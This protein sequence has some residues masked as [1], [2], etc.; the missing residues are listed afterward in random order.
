[1]YRAIFDHAP[2]AMIFLDDRGTILIANAA[3]V[4]LFEIPL[5]DLLGSHLRSYESRLLS[6]DSRLALDCFRRQGSLEGSFRLLTGNQTLRDFEFHVTGS[7]EGEHHL[8]VCR[9]VTERMEVERSLRLREKQLAQAQAIAQLG[10]WQWSPGHPAIEVS[11][12]ALRI[13]GF[14]AGEVDATTRLFRQALHPEDRQQVRLALWGA[15][16]RRSSFSVDYR[17]IRQDGATRTIRQ[18]GEASIGEDGRVRLLGVIRDI[19]EQKQIQEAR[20]KALRD[21]AAERTW[22]STL[23]ERS[24]VAF[25]LLGDGGRRVVFNRR[26]QE[27][28]GGDGGRLSLQQLLT[29]VCLPSGIRM[30]PSELPSTRALVGEWVLSEE[31]ALRRRDGTL[32]PA[33]AS[34][35]PI[36]D[37]DGKRLGAVVVFEDIRALKALDRMREEWT[38]IVAHDLRQP[39]TVIST[40]GQLLARKLGQTNPEL[41]APSEHILAS[42]GLLNRMVGDLLDMS[43]IEAHRLSLELQP[44]ELEALA[45]KV[46]ERLSQELEQQEVVIDASSPLPQVMVDPIRF[47]QILVN[48]LSNAAK[49]GERSAA[50]RVVLRR[51]EEGLTIEVIN[52]GRGI[53]QE[54]LAN[55]FTRFHRTDGAKKSRV[56]GLGLGLYITRGLVE[57]HGGGISAESSPGGNT[58]FRISLPH[59]SASVARVAPTPEA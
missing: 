35:G 32:I 56:G 37:E 59:A 18:E 41:L 15:V 9:D 43:R 53:P 54:E 27:L 10:H 45:R 12:Q 55:L 44:V 50:I 58:V 3:A 22:L 23:I 51:K 29:A 47:E 6:F 46:I 14:D 30:A 25:I 16:R 1:M 13:Y 24:P 34:A 28:I 39:L 36:E 42:V 57:A 11:D 8:A 20:E 19:T 17:I 49:Y 52:R 21:L 31:V 2:D 40:Q 48:L 4:R 33:L 5:S 26:A 7:I 38:S